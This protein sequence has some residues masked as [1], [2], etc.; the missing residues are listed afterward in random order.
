MSTLNQK[1]ESKMQLIDDLVAEITP[2]EMDKVKNKMIVSA[3]IEDLLKK[4]GI[5]KTEFAELTNKSKSIITRWLSGTQN[6]T[7]DVLTEISFYLNVSIEE[8]FIMP[9]ETKTYKSELNIK[10]T[11]VQQVYKTQT[12]V[13][14]ENES[15]N[16]F[17][18]PSISSLNSLCKTKTLYKE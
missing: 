13:V 2:L 8:L 3:R 15:Y 9:S 11:N 18:Y 5:S 1:S 14:I 10:I 4:K 6:L 16:E 12:W 7:I 17:I